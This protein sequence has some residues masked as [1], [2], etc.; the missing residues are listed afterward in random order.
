MTID[1][2]KNYTFNYAMLQIFFIC[3]CF[4]IQWIGKEKEGGVRGAA[5]PRGGAR[6]E[7]GARGAAG[8]ENRAPEAILRVKPDQSK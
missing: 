5:R 8:E 1:V 6:G 2:A 7:A 4:Q 3:S